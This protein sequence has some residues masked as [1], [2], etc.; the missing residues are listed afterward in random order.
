MELD[1]Y[2]IISRQKPGI[3]AHKAVPELE[4]YLRQQ[5]ESLMDILIKNLKLEIFFALLFL[6]FDGYILLFMVHNYLRVLAFLL[7]AFCVYFIYY[8]VTLLRSIQFQH[9][10]LSSVKHLLENYISIIQRFTRLYFQLTMVIIPLI[11]LLALFCGYLDYRAQPLRLDNSFSPQNI[12]AYLGISALWSFLM[13]F[14]TEWYIKKLYGKHLR[15]LKEQLK[16][17]REE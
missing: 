7:L 15:K 10:I 17:L 9:I 3:T 11:F 12:W 6:L 14:F 13:Y 8:L 4:Q 16:E 5:T 2:K 1:E